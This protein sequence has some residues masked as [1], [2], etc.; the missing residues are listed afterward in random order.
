MKL[1]GSTKEKLL[2]VLKKNGECTMKDIMTHFTISEIAIRRHLRELVQ[3]DFINEKVVKQEIGRPFHMYKLTSLGH[4]TFPNKNTSLPLEI[5]TDLEES[6]GKDAVLSVLE[7]RKKREQASYQDELTHKSFEEKIEFIAELQDSEGYMVEYKKN[8]DGSYEIK[9]FN[10]PIYSI[11]SN[12]GEIC[13]N[14][15]T[16]LENVFP[17]SQVTSHSKIT[18]GNKNCCWTISAPKVD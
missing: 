3:R 14:E 18:K 13:Q 7:K 1:K 2:M 8:P 10:C 4:E 15:K 12:Y 17:D 11:A 6:L 16:V 9:N 5:L